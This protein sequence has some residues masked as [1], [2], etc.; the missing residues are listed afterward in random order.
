M[1]RM[2]L[3]MV[4]LGALARP[5]LAQVAD[6]SITKTGPA[7]TLAGQYI[8]YTVS[9]T[10]NGPNAATGV[11]VS[12]TP[13]SGLT[14][15][16]NIGACTTT[17]PCSLGTMPAGQ[18]LT[19][20]SYF[21]LSP[22]VTG[23]VSNTATVSATTTDPVSSNNSATT[24]ATIVPPY[25][26]QAKTT[27]VPARA[28]STTEL[29]ADLII[30]CTGGVPY[31][32][33]T[34]IPADTITLTFNAN[35]TSRILN[36][37]NTAS[38]ALALVDEPQPGAQFPCDPSVVCAAYGNGTGN[39]YY[40][41]GTS[42]AQSPANR[43]VYQ[44]IVAANLY[45][46]GELRRASLGELRPRAEGGD[47]QTITWSGVP[48]DPPGTATRTYR[49]T[50]LRLDAT[51]VQ[52]PLQ[53]T[54]ISTYYLPVF[55]NSPLPIAIP[56]TSVTS[57]V[58]DAADAVL[59]PAGTSLAVSP[60]GLAPTRVATLRFAGAFPAADKPRT[61]AFVS[62][63]TSP[64]L[65][66]QNIPGKNYGTESGFFNTGFG[67]NGSG[68]N[69]GAAG[70]ADNGTR[71]MAVFS[72]IPAGFSVYVD[73]YSAAAGNG[74]V[75]R[76][77]STDANGAGSFTAVPGTGNMA[78]LTVNNGT[79]VAVWEVLR[80]NA[81]A[82][83]QFDFG[84]YLSSLAGIVVPPP[85]MAVQMKYAPFSPATSIPLFGGT[86]QAQTL[87]TFLP[88]AQLVAS[89][90]SLAFSGTAGGLNPPAQGVVLTSSSAAA[91]VVF[92][93][94]GGTLSYLFR[95]SAGTTPATVSVTPVTANLA[96][97]TYQDAIT[98]T[99]SGGYTGVRIAVTLT[100]AA[101]PKITAVS[102]AT[103]SA[104]GPA[105]NLT[106]NGTNF[107][108]GTVVQWNGSALPTSFG[109]AT[110]LTASVSAAL[111]S[112]P[113][114]ASITALTP[115]QSLS[116][117]V[118][119]A[120]T[121]P[122]LTALNP[123][124]VIAGGAGFTLTLSGTGFAAGATVSVG[125][126]T[127]QAVSLASTQITVAVPA[128]V[129]AQPASLAVTVSNPG[130]VVSNALTLTV[131]VLQLTSLAPSTVT[132]GGPAFTLTINGAGFAAGATV[133]VGS[134]ALQ[135]SALS[136]G[137]ITVTVPAAAIAQPASLP[138]TVTNP[139]N[140]VSNALPLTVSAVAI[141][142]LTPSSATAGSAAITLG[143]T[144]SGF[145]AG[146]AV[147]W[148]GQ[149]LATSV[150]SATQL[151]AQVPA[152]LLATAGTV[153][154]NVAIAG[155]AVSN[156]L[157][158]TINPAPSITALSP[159]SATPGSG[160]FTLTVSGSNFFPGATIL[161]NGQPLATTLAS[162]SQL[163]GQVPAALIASPGTVSVTVAS[164]DGV[165]SNAL[166]FTLKL[167]PLTGVG[168]TAPFQFD[169]RPEPAGYRKPECNLSGGP[170]GHVDADVRRPGRTAGRPGH[171]VP[172][173]KPR[174]HLHHSRRHAAVAHAGDG[175]HRHGGRHHH[176]HPDLHRRRNRRHPG[177]H[178][179]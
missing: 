36:S 14:F 97:G 52:G 35:V 81:V 120:V 167:P 15:E 175:E 54:G 26:C 110:Q 137:Q 73:L 66:N 177:R 2:G 39:G 131:S 139:G 119:V 58:R 3:W 74:N 96:P 169:L 132:A 122:Q 90:L 111:I 10:N 95:P 123:S 49:F 149:A 105:F 144:G 147:K 176:H 19:I 155:G 157:P 82:A 79:A 125:A 31:G 115:D 17:Y 77:V 99:G 107:V 27:A 9:V 164:V 65:V 92:T 87:V 11:T 40:G 93:V 89:P 173:R 112:R 53:V 103:V 70:L 129:I 50:N 88:P 1:K 57:G 47:S 83:D 113:G 151:T 23:S 174:F 101:A 71:Y 154:V 76:L 98:V 118:P 8:L 43:N 13:P 45:S 143:V 121:G 86:A 108:A 56:Q 127:L 67:N 140:L 104:G 29:V 68:G 51:S 16:E 148:N 178:R 38:E 165:S 106:V 134:T 80:N 158:F 135:P 7:L 42:T 141:T 33:G 179:A 78:Q 163:T 161:W 162:V 6:L 156:S 85:P 34:E 24:T 171:P 18:T 136:A 55:G 94:T 152:A 124:T 102:P 133:N 145:V 130:N 146:D 72:N 100:L 128:G 91:P 46:E 61:A 153:Q 30:T 28:E 64:A 159:G 75:A 37:S 22:T 117:S 142:A 150:V 166:P 21:Y 84:V 60:V 20:S 170:A 138:V 48:I 12:D 69:L 5:A 59:A 32:A 44:G 116:N 126:S 41:G 25:T 62:A 109:S 160:A 4:L 114:T 63:D 168:L 172:E